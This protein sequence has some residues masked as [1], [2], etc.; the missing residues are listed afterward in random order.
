MERGAEEA[1]VVGEET[2]GMRVVREMLRPGV[3]KWE[4]S[5]PRERSG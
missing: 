1:A 3:E 5:E 2:D 4:L